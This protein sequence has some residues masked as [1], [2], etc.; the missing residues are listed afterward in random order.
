MVSWVALISR[1]LRPDARQEASRWGSGPPPVA[2]GGSNA[3]RSLT[4]VWYGS[5]HI[6]Q[7]EFLFR[8][9]Q[10]GGG[11]NFEVWGK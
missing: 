7:F 2:L 5:R 4:D 10:L 3:T 11:E 6:G 8:D 9:M 1:A